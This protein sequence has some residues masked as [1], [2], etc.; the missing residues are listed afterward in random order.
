MVFWVKIITADEAGDVVEATNKETSSIRRTDAPSFE[1]LV[2]HSSVG[3]VL[4]GS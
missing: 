3:S 1:I 2:D 4:S